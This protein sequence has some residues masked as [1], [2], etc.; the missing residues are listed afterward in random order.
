MG[1]RRNLS[2]KNIILFDKKDRTD[3]NVHEFFFNFIEKSKII[4]GI[5]EIY[6]LPKR[7]VIFIITNT[8]YRL[9]SN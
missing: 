7:S 9:L 3:K 2:K 4:T 5:G 6:F 8:E 1:C